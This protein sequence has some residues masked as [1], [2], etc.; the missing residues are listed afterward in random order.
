[1]KRLVFVLIL[2]M[3]QGVV[4]GAAQPNPIN[5]QIKRTPMDR[6]VIRLRQQN[7]QIQ[8]DLRAGKLTKDQAKTLKVQ[9]E[10]I[11]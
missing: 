3:A 11:R 5:T 6:V 4:F 10:T 2:M 9:V 8:R 7:I 1:M